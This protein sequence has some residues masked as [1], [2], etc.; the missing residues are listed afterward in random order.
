MEIKYCKHPGCTELVNKRGSCA[1]HMITPQSRREYL[2]KWREKNREKDLKSKRDYRVSERGKIQN[3]NY[4][5]TP[6]CRFNNFLKSQ[7]ARGI[8]VDLSFEEFCRITSTGCYYC[9]GP[10][11]K[12]GAGLDRIDSSL[13]YTSSNVLPCCTFCNRLKADLLTVEET[14][15]IIKLL[16]QLRAKDAIWENFTWG[17]AIKSR[18]AEIVKNLA[19]A[20]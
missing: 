20:K 18:N 4:W 9:A 19:E 11:P 16:K 2:K 3:K 7:K 12:K 13:G 17:G 5:A 15:N 1:K 10:L 14:L 8:L 6:V